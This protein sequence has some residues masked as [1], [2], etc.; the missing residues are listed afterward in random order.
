MEKH[1][2][3]FICTGNYYRSRFAEI[4]FNHLAHK[5]DVNKT[6]F[7]RG[8]EADQSRNEGAISI[9]TKNYL[10]EL[11]IQYDQERYPIQL[12]A[13]DL[14]KGH[15]I[16]LMDSR[17]HIPMLEKYFPDWNG[18]FIEWELGDLHIQPSD[19]ILP[20]IKKEIDLLIHSEK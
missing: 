10:D 3:L 20:L 6:A 17:E 4:Y 19:I 11:G 7:S 14:Q 16:I 5:F 15:R 9:H 8:F 18:S 13:E 12:K 1:T 2:T